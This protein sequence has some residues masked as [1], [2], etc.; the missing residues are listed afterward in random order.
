MTKSKRRVL[1]QYQKQETK[2]N[3]NCR[4]FPSRN[5]KPDNIPVMCT[6]TEKLFTDKCQHCGWNPV[7]KAE[8]LKK[9][10]G[11][12]KA[13]AAVEYSKSITENT[14]PEYRRKWGDYKPTRKGDNDV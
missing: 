5:Y 14:N 10:Y 1:V 12:K 7:V 4:S 6:E 2:L 8:R 9:M 13:N 3:T 11:E